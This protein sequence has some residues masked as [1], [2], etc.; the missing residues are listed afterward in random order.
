LVEPVSST[1]RTSRHNSP[2]RTRAPSIDRADSGGRSRSSYGL[3]T[4]LGYV[5]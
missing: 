3:D 4:W 2:G 5:G 1:T